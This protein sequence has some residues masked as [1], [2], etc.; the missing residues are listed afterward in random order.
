MQLDQAAVLDPGEQA[1]LASCGPIW[2]AGIL[3]RVRRLGFESLTAEVTATPASVSPT[4]L[5]LTT[6]DT[7]WIML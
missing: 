5:T 3:L 7:G 2:T 6:T 1:S 4:S